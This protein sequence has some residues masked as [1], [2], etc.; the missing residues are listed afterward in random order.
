MALSWI[1]ETNTK[2]IPI[3]HYHLHIQCSTKQN[4]KIFSWNLTKV[5]RNLSGERGKN[6]QDN[7]K[8]V[9]SGVNSPSNHQIIL[10]IINYFNYYQ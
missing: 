3:L 9:Q 6:T 1:S 10:T 8:E 4:H 5:I 2:S 7:I